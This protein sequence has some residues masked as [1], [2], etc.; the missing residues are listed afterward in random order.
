MWSW[1][2]SR[3]GRL[4]TTSAA[5]LDRLDDAPFQEEYM[6]EWPVFT[7][8]GYVRSVRRTRTK[9]VG[10]RRRPSSSCPTTNLGQ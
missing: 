9:Q 10:L 7:K 5:M 2:V 4:L 3:T 6:Y 8:D 1:L